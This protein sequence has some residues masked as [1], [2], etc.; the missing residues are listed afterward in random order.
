MFDWGRLKCLYQL[1]ETF[2][3]FTGDIN[4][5]RIAV[6][7]GGINCADIVDIYDRGGKALR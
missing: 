5:Q 3:M 1:L 6:E 4:D 7:K 2:N